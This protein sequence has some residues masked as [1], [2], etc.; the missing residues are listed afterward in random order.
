MGEIL[1]THVDSAAEGRLS[2]AKCCDLKN[3]KKRIAAALNLSMAA[4]WQIEKFAF[5]LHA[6]YPLEMIRNG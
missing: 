3:I 4:N 5:P 1:P 6:L 2:S